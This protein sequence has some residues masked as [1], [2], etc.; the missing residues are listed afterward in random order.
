MANV[1]SEKHFNLKIDKPSDHESI[2]K[3]ARALSVD[4][5]LEILKYLLNRSVSLSEI[6][7]NLNIDRKSVV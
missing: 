5:R 4:V 1:S 7:K 6:S 2:A 3:I